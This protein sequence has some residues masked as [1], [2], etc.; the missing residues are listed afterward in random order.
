MMCER[1]VRLV[2]SVWVVGVQGRE[3]LNLQHGGREERR[4]GTIHR[5]RGFEG[6][7]GGA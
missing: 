3:F 2:I 7:V 5:V 1:E 6:Q 4:R